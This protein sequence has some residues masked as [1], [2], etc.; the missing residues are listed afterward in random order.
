MRHKKKAQLD[1]DFH[2]QRVNIPLTNFKAIAR[3]PLII[4]LGTMQQVVSLQETI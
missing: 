2:I 4:K 3:K 1:S